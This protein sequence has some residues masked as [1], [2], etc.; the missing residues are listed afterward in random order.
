M[1][2]VNE[3][4][5]EGGREIEGGRGIKGEKERGREGKGRETEN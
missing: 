3:E 1:K 5:K 4:R 2:G